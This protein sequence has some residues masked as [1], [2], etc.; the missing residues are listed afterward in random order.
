MEVDALEDLSAHTRLERDRDP[1]EEALLRGVN[2][3]VRGHVR[4]D[5]GG[6]V[7]DGVSAYA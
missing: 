6:E 1:V 3:G 7:I 5:E 2:G 4:V